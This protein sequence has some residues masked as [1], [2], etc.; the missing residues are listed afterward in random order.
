MDSGAIINMHGIEP[1]KAVKLN[2][3]LRSIEITLHVTPIQIDETIEISDNGDR[4]EFDEYHEQLKSFLARC[5]KTGLD[6]HN[7]PSAALISASRRPMYAVD[8]ET[9]EFFNIF[10][11][12]M[13]RLEKKKQ[14]YDPMNITRDTIIAT[15]ALKYDYLITTDKNMRNSM[16]YSLKKTNIDSKVQIKYRPPNKKNSILTWLIGLEKYQD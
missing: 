15:S 10:W 8:K 4:L 12:K 16:K 7:D 13:H 1:Q 3:H 14:Q 2:S 5:S 11:E 9:M 6:I